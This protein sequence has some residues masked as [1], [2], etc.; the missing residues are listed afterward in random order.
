MFFVVCINPS[1]LWNLPSAPR[2]FS[3]ALIVN[4]IRHYSVTSNNL[5]IILIFN[6]EKA[7]IN[8]YWQEYIYGIF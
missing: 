8:R 4:H 6:Y 2:I 3:P 1:N 7:S 5:Y